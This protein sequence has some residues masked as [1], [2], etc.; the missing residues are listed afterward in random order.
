MCI[1]DRFNIPKEIKYP[2]W[3]DVMLTGPTNKVVSAFSLNTTNRGDSLLSSFGIP[4]EFPAVIEHTGEYKF[5]YF[6]GDFCDNPIDQ[7]WAKF[8]FIHFFEWIFFDN[9]EVS[10]RRSFFWQYYSPLVT[11]ILNDDYASKH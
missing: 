4:K 3:F 6:A 11:S 8:E 5:Y 2:Y 9:N 7:F 1:R 10:E